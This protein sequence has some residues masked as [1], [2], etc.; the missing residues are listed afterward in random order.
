MSSGSDRGEPRNKLR[1]LFGSFIVVVAAHE[2]AETRTASSSLL[3]RAGFLDE[4]G[5][6]RSVKSRCRGLY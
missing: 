2:D 6:N 1:R 5:A 3:N 4:G